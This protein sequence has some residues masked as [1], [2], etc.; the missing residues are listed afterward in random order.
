MIM[1]SCSKNLFCLLNF[2]CYVLVLIFS[3][4][5]MNNFFFI[6]DIVG[7]FVV[8]F[9]GMMNVLFDDESERR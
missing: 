2:L 7:M 6:L 3:C 4:G 5:I 8:F 9:K 1:V